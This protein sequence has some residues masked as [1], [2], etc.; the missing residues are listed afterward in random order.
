MN[1]KITPTKV[2][3]ALLF[4]RGPQMENSDPEEFE[5]DKVI[6]WFLLNMKTLRHDDLSK[7]DQTWLQQQLERQH[8]RTKDLRDLTPRRPDPRLFLKKGRMLESHRIERMTYEDD[9]FQRDSDTS[10][11][12][13]ISAT[14]RSR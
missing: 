8:K 7:A 5:M 11:L 14:H 4:I 10:F 12:P 13:K 3:D 6:Q 2:L 9:E 1:L